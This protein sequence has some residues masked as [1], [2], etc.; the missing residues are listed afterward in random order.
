MGQWAI[1][2]I[3]DKVLR[4]ILDYIENQIEIARAKKRA[5]NKIK[6]IMLEED[7]IKRALNLRRFLQ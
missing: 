7:P 5:K 6:E 2:I 3:L 1:S 4:F